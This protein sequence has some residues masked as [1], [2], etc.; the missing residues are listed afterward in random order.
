MVGT[1]PEASQKTH[2]Y[3]AS[4]FQPSDMVATARSTSDRLEWAG[5][6]RALATGA[7]R[8]TSVGF[9]GTPAPAAERSRQMT[10]VL[11]TVNQRS[12]G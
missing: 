11:G 10:Y 6:L 2:S 7:R 8:S 5:S 3:S 1:M 9:I 12:S 4:K